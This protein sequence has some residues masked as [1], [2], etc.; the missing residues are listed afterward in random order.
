MDSQVAKEFGVTGG[1]S[2]D[3]S[4]NHS[5]DVQRAFKSRVIQFNK[6][7]VVGASAYDNRNVASSPMSTSF[8]QQRLNTANENRS[9][10]AAAPLVSV[11]KLNHSLYTRI[12]Y[13]ASSLGKRFTHKSAPR[14][15][16]D[17]QGLGNSIV[18][19]HALIKHMPPSALNEATGF[20]TQADLA[21]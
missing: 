20:G 18:T 15:Q 17:K 16:S 3:K 5:V 1:E 9:V 11:N 4:Q 13:N 21:N 19:H 7:N 6:L 2:F 10:E 12:Q 14:I 8:S